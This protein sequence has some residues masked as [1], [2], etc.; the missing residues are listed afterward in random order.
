MLDEHGVI[1]RSARKRL[2]D[3]LVARR[4]KFVADL[5]TLETQV[6]ELA[7]WGDHSEVQRY[8]KKSNALKSRLELASQKITSF[9]SEETA[10]GWSLTE[11]PSRESLTLKLEPYTELYAAIVDWNRCEALW[12]DGAF[13]EVEAD[14]V[15]TET[16]ACWRALYKAQKA[17][18][19]EPEPL[20]LAQKTR[21]EVDAFH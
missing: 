13:C 18:A 19:S 8:Q 21:G 20:Q 4:R 7:G 17:F 3:D 16:G 1:M 6:G 15:E 5:A 11:Y 10:F 14:T 12:M 9:N 2:E